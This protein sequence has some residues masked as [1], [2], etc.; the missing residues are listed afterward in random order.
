MRTSSSFSAKEPPACAWLLHAQFNVAVHKRLANPDTDQIFPEYIREF[1]D[2]RASYFKKHLKG[3]HLISF[4]MPT[5]LSSMQ[6]GQ[7]RDFV[8]MEGVFLGS[9]SVSDRTLQGLFDSSVTTQ[10]AAFYFGQGE[11]FDDHAVFRAFLRKSSL[12]G[13]DPALKFRVDYIGTSEARQP[14]TK[15]GDDRAKAWKFEAELDA[16]HHA[17]LIH[18]R[19]EINSD[20]FHLH[21]LQRITNWE[22]I[23]ES[24]DLVSYSVQRNI[25]SEHARDPVPVVGYF[26]HRSENLR[27]REVQ[28]MLNGFP[29][30]TVNWSAVHVGKGGSLA[31]NTEYQAFLDAS[32]MDKDGADSNQN[33]RTP[34]TS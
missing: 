27:R 16:E 5:N 13:M 31:S 32:T 19:G 28:D 12:G 29:G 24:Y 6:N 18:V 17:D 22:N 7:S 25:L 4:A 33:K 21:I 20:Y 30:L 14:S 3:M 34:L 9:H 8:L 1:F 10:W 15:K 2:A 11:S 23:K 26:R